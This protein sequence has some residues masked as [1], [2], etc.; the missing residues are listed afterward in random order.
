MAT[1]ANAL[2]VMAKAPIGGEVKTR[3][4]PPLSFQEAAELYRSLLL[5]LLE[6]VGSFQGADRYVAFSP[7]AAATLFE[8]LLPFGFSCFAQRGGD[9]GERMKNI[10]DELF[11]IGH[12]NV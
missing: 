2:V 12:R 6:W 4:V 7:A 3:L 10:F 11:G 5:D 1:R 8:Q 9:L